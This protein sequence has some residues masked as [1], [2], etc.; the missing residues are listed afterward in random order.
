MKPLRFGNN[1]PSQ[2][3]KNMLSKSGAVLATVTPR[4]PVLNLQP[5]LDRICVTDPDTGMESGMMGG[6]HLPGNS[7]V[8]V[9][10]ARVKV[11]AIGPDVKSL[12]AG[13]EVLVPRGAVQEV[14]HDGNSYFWANEA[15]VV[16]IV[17]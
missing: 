2:S 11:L 9:G 4:G 14:G 1:P 17:R 8:G 7:T 16:G 5:V 12:K 13:N 3:D 10:F 15:T 6:I